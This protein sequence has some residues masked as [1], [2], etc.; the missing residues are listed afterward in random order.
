MRW[1]RQHQ[2]TASTNQTSICLSIGIYIEHWGIDRDGST[3]PWVRP[4]KYAEKMAWAQE[5]A[6]INGTK[7]VE[8]FSWEKQD[9]TLL[10]ALKPSWKLLGWRCVQFRRQCTDAAEGSGADQPA[11]EAGRHV[12]ELVQVG[13]LRSGRS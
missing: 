1:T 2:I 11:D 13:R 5:H 6:Q 4:P 9:G 10:S 8:T 3:A 12:P 7:L